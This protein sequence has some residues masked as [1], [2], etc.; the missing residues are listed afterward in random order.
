MWSKSRS[1]TFTKYLTL[2]FM[3]TLI[4]CAFF[5]PSLANS[6]LSHKRDGEQIILPLIIT[7]YASIP[8]ALVLLGCLFRLTV[9]IGSGKVFE[10]ANTT[11]LRVISW[12]SFLV[13]L[14]YLG[15]SFV[16]LFALLMTIAAVFIGL[17]LR[18]IKNVFEQAII[19]KDENDFTI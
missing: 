12:C 1:L 5:L 8:P 2:I 13:G 17:I 19:L 10:R 15:F 9:N 16:Y 11:L 7:L 6:Y 3:V 4:I 14:I 18:V